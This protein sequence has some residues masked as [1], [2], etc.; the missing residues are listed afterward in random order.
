MESFPPSSGPVTV[1]P[2]TYYQLDGTRRPAAD[3]LFIDNHGQFTLLKMSIS[4]RASIETKELQDLANS[5][6]VEVSK[7][8]WQLIFV[9]PE[10]RAANFEACMDN[11][12]WAR[13]LDLYVLPLHLDSEQCN[14]L[15]LIPRDHRLFH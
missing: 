15:D 5:L 12:G 13:K 6:P 4:D 2:G 1:T 3:A 7:K 11:K 8:T 9:V 14:V 10:G